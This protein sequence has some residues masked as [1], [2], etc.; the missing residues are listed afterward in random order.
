M[1]PKP[2]RP[3]VGQAPAKPLTCFDTVVAF[4][5]AD[6]WPFEADDESGT[7]TTGYS[8]DNGDYEVVLEAKNEASMFAVHV[9]LPVEH[10]ADNNDDD[11]PA[12]FGELVEMVLKLNCGLAV[13]SFDLD[14]DDGSLRFR[15][16]VLVGDAAPSPA[17]VRDQIYAAVTSADLYFTLLQAVAA[18]ELTAEAA[19]EKLAAEANAEDQEAAAD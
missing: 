5:K 16:G 19:L 8:G 7:V 18:G 12:A 3:A 2:F 14:I 9:D 11:A 1:P 4:L 6:D 10:Q 15:I 17:L 13:G